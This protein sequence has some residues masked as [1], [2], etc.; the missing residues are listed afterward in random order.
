MIREIEKIIPENY[1]KILDFH[2]PSTRCNMNGMW[3]HTAAAVAAAAVVAASVD[4][5]AVVDLTVK[6]SLRKVRDWRARI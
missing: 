2:S 5:A 4:F 1:D 3:I 6:R